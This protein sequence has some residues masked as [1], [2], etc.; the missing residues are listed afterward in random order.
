[1]LQQ[2]GFGVTGFRGVFQVIGQRGQFPTDHPNFRGSFD[3]DLNAPFAS[4][5]HTDDNIV[6]D[7]DDV[8][9]LSRQN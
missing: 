7:P 8:V 4:P 2:Q 3:P 6:T 9:S 1:V 5:D